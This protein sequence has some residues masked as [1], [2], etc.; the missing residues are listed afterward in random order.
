MEYIYV[1]P[2]DLCLIRLKFSESDAYTLFADAN[3]RPIHRWT[4]SSQ[5]YSF[6]LLERPK[7]PF[8][9]RKTPSSES[10]D[11]TV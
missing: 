5:R 4:D 3:L 8:P 10:L 6:W 1:L 7:F 9:L 2:F 11:C